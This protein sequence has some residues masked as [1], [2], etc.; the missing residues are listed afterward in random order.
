MRIGAFD[1]EPIVR[2]M[3]SVAELN[4][5]RAPL[6]KYIHIR[7]ARGNSRD[8]LTIS[9]KIGPWYTREKAL[10]GLGEDNATAEQEEHKLIEG[11]TLP[12]QVPAG[13]YQGRLS[14]ISNT[15]EDSYP[16]SIEIV[17]AHYFPTDFAHAEYLSA[18]VNGFCPALKQFAEKIRGSVVNSSNPSVVMQALYNALLEKNLTYQT[19]V[20]PDKPDFQHALPLEYVLEHGGS[21]SDL[22]LLFASLLWSLGLSPALILFKDHMAVGVFR[23]SSPTKFSVLYNTE[24]ILRYVHS[25]YLYPVQII[26]VCAGQGLSYEQAVSEIT[27]RMEKSHSSFCLVGVQN[28]RQIE[29]IDPIAPEQFQQIVC[30]ECGWPNVIPQNESEVICHACR[31]VIRLPARVPAN[32]VTVVR[33]IQFTRAGNHSFVRHAETDIPESLVIPPEWQSCPVTVIGKRSFFGTHVCSVR[34]PASVI[35]IED[36]AFYGCSCLKTVHLPS[37]LTTLGSGA[38]ASS[39]LESIRIPGSLKVIPSMAFSSCTELKEIIL[40]EGIEKIDA[41]AFSGCPALKS[42]TIPSTVKVVSRSAFD[43]ACQLCFLSSDTV[44]R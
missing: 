38:F 22:S 28:C 26:G 6:L 33:G 13:R 10:R 11:L 20:T 24:E 15:E 42:A 23:E 1:V 7:N 29:K 43:K 44:I 5:G 39:A 2:D 14:F 37:G 36:Q 16:F 32:T 30:P 34:L 18:Y 3:I 41:Q 27:A 19:V 31:A 12:A 25:G 9:A 40:E 21:C 17:P 35:R 4:T 8:Y